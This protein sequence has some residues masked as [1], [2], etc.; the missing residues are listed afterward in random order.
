MIACAAVQIGV[1]IQSASTTYAQG[2]RTTAEGVY[3]Q[4]QAQRGEKT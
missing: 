3:T 1:G 4:E 2:G